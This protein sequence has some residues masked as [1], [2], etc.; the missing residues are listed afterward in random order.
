M[1]D[2]LKKYISYERRAFHAEEW[3][4]VVVWHFDEAVRG[5]RVYFTTRRGG[6]SERPYKSL[7]LGFHVGD[8]PERVRRNRE[9]LAGNL[10][11]D[12]GAITSPRQRHSAV[13]EEL[14]D[15]SAVGAGSGGAESAARF[16]PCDG[17]VTAMRRRPLLLHF[18][19]CVP[20]VVTARA[21]GRPLLAAIH[22]GR[23]G[24][25]EGVVANGVERLKGME[26]AAGG[27]SP[28]SAAIGP[29]IGPCCYEVDA[30]TATAFAER[31]GAELVVDNHLDLRQ[32]VW[33]ELESAGIGAGDIHLLDLCTA[34]DTENF[35]SYRREGVT[36][37]QGALAWLE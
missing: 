32:A 19:D 15:E 28:V 34:C 10:G 2:L 9:L 26:A 20:V 7:N 21:A 13:V 16:D 30:Q 33:R 24:L 31:F 29:S 6:V 8:D 25:M 4:P 22:A 12:P 3:G 36:G 5:A 1:D 27:I 35:Y 37:R 14:G 11:L 23:A 18:A 17:L